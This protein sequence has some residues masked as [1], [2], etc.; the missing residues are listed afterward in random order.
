MERAKGDVLLRSVDVT[1]HF[2][3]DVAI[4]HLATA[5]QQGSCAAAHRETTEGSEGQ[6]SLRRKKK[7]R[8]TTHDAALCLEPVRE[9]AAGELLLLGGGHHDALS[10]LNAHQSTA[11]SALS[12]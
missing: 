10:L 4:R 9:P 3:R 7:E 5:R 1:A 11:W 6:I 12:M 2:A 8:A